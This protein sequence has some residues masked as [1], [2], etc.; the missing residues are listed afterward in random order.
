MTI[1]IAVA[2]IIIGATAPCHIGDQTES[3]TAQQMRVQEF[4]VGWTIFVFIDP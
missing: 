2:F 4:S 3:T 1:G